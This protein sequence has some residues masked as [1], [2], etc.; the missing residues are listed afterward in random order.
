MPYYVSKMEI[1]NISSSGRETDEKR[2]RF[3]NTLNDNED[4]HLHN[5]PKPIHIKIDIVIHEM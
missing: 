4:S 2:R 3:S 1:N 5:K